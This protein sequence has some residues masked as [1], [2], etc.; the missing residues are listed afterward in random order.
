[1]RQRLPK[2]T[3]GFTL[4][5]LVVALAV[6]SLLAA[7]AYTGLN[8]VLHTTHQATL[9]TE[10]LARLQIAVATLSR[11]LSQVADRTIR[12]EF[13]DRRGALL[14]GGLLGSAALEFS[15]AGYRNPAGATRS[16]LQRVGYQLQEGRLIRTVWSVLD[17]A[18]DTVP[19][20]TPLLEGVRSFAV[21]FLDE[22]S[23][24]QDQWPSA[25]NQ[26]STTPRSLP[27]AVSVTLDLTDF[28]AITRSYILP[29]PVQFQMTG[30]HQ[31]GQ[32][33]GMQQNPPG[34]LQ[35]EDQ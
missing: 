1:M 22:N 32:N 11:D 23:Q 29:I 5:E 4:V 27:V 14:G 26:S 28:G 21:R 16:S 33:T 17:R 9:Q 20:A 2:P 31:S 30:T 18:Q 19:L 15:R 8:T 24:W 35:S 10:R 7:M 6:F 25:S 3:A 13:G 12:D 34:T